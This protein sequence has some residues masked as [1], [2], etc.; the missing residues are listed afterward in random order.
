M[1]QLTGLMDENE[2]AKEL[3]IILEKTGGIL[4]SCL[5][6]DIDDFRNVNVVYDF[7]FGD[8]VLIQF[9]ALL[10]TSV[11]LAGLLGRTQGNTFLAVLPRVPIT[12][13]QRI[14]DDIRERVERETF[15][16]AGS[17]LGLTVSIGGTHGMIEEINKGRNLLKAALDALY[18]A[19]D[20]GRNGTVIREVRNQ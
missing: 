13:A 3:N 7:P 17:T 4:L 10:R 1:D 16:R 14:A 12:D 19:K 8:K 11:R 20:T 6:I 18:E 5:Y 2:I 9:A 15:G